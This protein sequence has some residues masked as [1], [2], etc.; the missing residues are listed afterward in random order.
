[1][2]KI[3]VND[4]NETPIRLGDKLNV[5]SDDFE[6][7][8][9]L[10]EEGVVFFDEI[11]NIFYLQ[12]ER[13]QILL[14]EKHRNNYTIVSRNNLEVKSIG[15]VAKLLLICFSALLITMFLICKFQ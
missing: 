9:I 8:L 13:G 5:S 10:N 14:S 7:E 6:G 12:K 4:K 3:G 1:M 11:K 15:F 2:N